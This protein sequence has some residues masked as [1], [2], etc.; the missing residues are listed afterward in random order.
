MVLATPLLLRPGSASDDGVRNICLEP[1]APAESEEVFIATA[2]ACPFAR[3]P[4]QEHGSVPQIS[5]QRS[6]L[7][8]PNTRPS[9]LPVGTSHLLVLIPEV[10]T[11]AP[12]PSD[13][14]IW[15]SPPPSGPFRLSDTLRRPNSSGPCSRHP[16]P[17]PRTCFSLRP[18]SL[19]PA[20]F[21]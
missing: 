16:E 11:P 17:G 13:P 5:G 18:K 20:P 1:W 15:V 19:G 12:P 21:P 6:K 7:A 3:N 4:T 14:G 9:V 8:L 2:S 10:H